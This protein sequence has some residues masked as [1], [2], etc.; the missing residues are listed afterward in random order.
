MFA[1]YY[2]EIPGI[3][4]SI[5]IHEIKTYPDTKLVRQRLGLLHPRKVVAIKIEVEKLLKVGFIYLVPL[6]DWVS[7]IVKLIKSKELFEYVS[8]T[9]TLINLVPKTT[10]QP[11]ISIKLLMIVMEM[12]FSLSW[13]VLP[14]TIK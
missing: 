10:I 3:D 14:I 2:E 4:P 5:V 12:K 7:N 1:R 11:R 6:T 9:G 13:M 8:I